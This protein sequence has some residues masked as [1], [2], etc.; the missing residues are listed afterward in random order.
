MILL[1]LVLGKGCDSQQEKDLSEAVVEYTANTRGFYFKI[2]IQ[3]KQALI[4]HDRSGAQKPEAKAISEA[5]WKA[6]VSE[7]SKVDLEKL[8]GYKAP[9][10]KRFYDGA[11]MADLKV[12]YQGKEYKSTTFDHGTPPT[13]I[14]ALV[15]KI[16]AFAPNRGE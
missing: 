3:D 11:A 16:T 2:A 4:S 10:E 9:T 1:T 5:D 7:F 6:L 14:A 15:E 13:E 12:T 8:P